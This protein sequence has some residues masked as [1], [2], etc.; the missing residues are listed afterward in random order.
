M[1]IQPRHFVRFIDGRAGNQINIAFLPGSLG[2]HILTLQTAVSLRLDYARKLIRHG[3]MYEGFSYIQDTIDNGMCL[4]EDEYRLKFLYVRDNIQPEIYFLLL[5]TDRSRNELWLVTFH[6]IRQKQFT[7]RL[8]PESI[9][10][11]H[12][13]REFM[14]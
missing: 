3:V 13:E 4:I 6:R 1:I 14:G 10:R 11:E 9:I 7:G 8:D 2:G 12:S 5:K